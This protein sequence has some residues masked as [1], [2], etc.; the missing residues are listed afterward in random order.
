[1]ASDSTVLVT[2]ATGLLGS[3]L[4]RQLVDDGTPVRIFRRERSS[5]GLLGG[6]ADRVEH[7]VGDLRDV[8]SLVRAMDGIDRVYHVAA[9]IGTAARDRAALRAVNVAG[10]ANVVNAANHVGVDRLV[11]TSSI[12]ALGRPMEPDAVLDETAAWRD[13]PSGSDYA[14]SKYDAEREVHRSIAEGL[15][16]VI[17]NPALIFG[18]GRSGENTRRIVDAVRRGWVLAVPPGGTNVVDAAD[19][20]AGLRAALRHGTT[21]ERYILGSENRSW[22][23][24]VSTLAEAFGVEPPRRIVP[25]ALLRAGAAVSEAIAFVTRT[26]PLLSRALAESAV[27]QRRY[28]TTK[29]RTEIGCTFRPFAATARRIAG[30]IDAG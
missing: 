10:T 16:A 4:T 28:D 5:L 8:R 9:K 21:G 3:V 22:H 17:V 26:N 12:A 29:A 23:E 25:P 24:I 15:D 2:G 14:Q 7:A 1:M 13:A 18:V 27:R 19:V 6:V 11:H 20:A 30:V